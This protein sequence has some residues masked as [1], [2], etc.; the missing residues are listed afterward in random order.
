[1]ILT[2]GNGVIRFAPSLVISEQ[3]IREGMARLATAA[4]KLFG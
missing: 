4:E 2:A 1:M 3:D